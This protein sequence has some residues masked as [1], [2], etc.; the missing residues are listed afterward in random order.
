MWELATEGKEREWLRELPNTWW[1]PVVEMGDAAG[2]T[3][4]V[5]EVRGNGFGSEH[6]RLQIKL[7]SLTSHSTSRIFQDM[8]CLRYI[9][10]EF[11][12]CFC[13]IL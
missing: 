5:A 6:L 10:V 2:G 13:I 1:Y 4:L 3:N 9:I 12:H 8:L 7:L 11:V